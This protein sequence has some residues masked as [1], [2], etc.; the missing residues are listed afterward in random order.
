MIVVDTNVQ[1]YLALN[2]EKTAQ[3]EAAFRRDPHWVAP[4][5][6]RSEFLSVLAPYLRR[7]LLTQEAAVIVMTQAEKLLQTEYRVA[8][9]NVLRLVATNTCSIYDCE[10]AALAR[11]LDVKL[12]TEDRQLLE[13]FP[14]QAVS[15]AGFLGQA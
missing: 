12:L 3:A 15:L 14:S 6:W 13:Q 7:G 5:L 9:A 1:A 10:Y 4:V 8:P 2:G 11:E